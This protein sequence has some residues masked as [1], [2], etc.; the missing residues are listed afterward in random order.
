MDP[1]TRCLEIARR[2]SEASSAHGAYERDTLAGV[3]DTQW[4][5]WYANYLV[6]NGWNSLFAQPWSDRALAAALRNADTD[7]RARAPHDPWV[8]HYARH[9]CAN[10]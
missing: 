7:H 3:Y 5:E 4:A 6:N 8:E 10:P 9:F 1:V 2:L